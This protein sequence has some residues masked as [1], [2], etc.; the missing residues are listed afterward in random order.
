MCD[1]IDLLTSPCAVEL[2][3]HLGL[4]VDRHLCAFR[5][6][7]GAAEV[8]PK[9]HYMDHAGPA[10]RKWNANLSCF[11][12]ERRRRVAKCVADYGRDPNLG[13]A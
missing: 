2:A 4:L 13:R 10:M 12:M 8:K 7:C 1:I 3:D 9:S 6:A 5:A 11:A